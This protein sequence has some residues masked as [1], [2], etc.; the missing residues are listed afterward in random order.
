MANIFL[1]SYPAFLLRSYV[2][3]VIVI[4]AAVVHL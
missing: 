1:V 2:I 3:V 4:C